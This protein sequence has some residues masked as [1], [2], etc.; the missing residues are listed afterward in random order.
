MGDSGKYASILTINR[1]IFTISVALA[2]LY[3]IMRK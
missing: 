2:M 1:W 3:R